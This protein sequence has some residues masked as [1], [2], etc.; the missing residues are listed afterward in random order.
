MKKEHVSWKSFSTCL[1]KRLNNYKPDVSM[2]SI[3]GVLLR[4][5][6]ESRENHAPRVRN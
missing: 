1:R 4:E 6:F 2:K 5:K 3:S